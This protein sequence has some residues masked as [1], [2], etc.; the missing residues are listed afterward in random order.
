MPSPSHSSSPL[1]SRTTTQNHHHRCPS[2]T[3]QQSTIAAAQTTANR[4][5]SSPWPPLELRPSSIDASTPFLP[6]RWV[7]CNKT[8]HA[9]QDH[10]SPLNLAGGRPNFRCLFTSDD[11][12]SPPQFRP[13]Q[14]STVQPSPLP[15]YSTHLPHSHHRTHALPKCSSTHLPKCSSTTIL[16]RPTSESTYPNF[17]HEPFNEPSVS[18]VTTSKGIQQHLL[19]LLPHKTSFVPITSSIISF[20]STMSKQ[21]AAFAPGF[22][23]PP[24]KKKAA[25]SI[26]FAPNTKS[27][28]PGLVSSTKMAILSKLSNATSISNAN[29]LK[30]SKL[31]GSPPLLPKRMRP[32]SPR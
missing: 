20:T 9:A 1:L 19:H 4:P 26:S 21:S 23:P 31:P 27:R 2:T 8:T 17:T 13:V 14:N 30:K 15:N 10:L 5:P 25:S 32:P 28:Q 6:C 7:D 3:P 11:R 16:N 12:P 22:A 24:S 29:V 18:I